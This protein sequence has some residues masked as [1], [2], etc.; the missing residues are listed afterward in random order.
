[1]SQISID[2]CVESEYSVEVKPDVES[3]LLQ[4]TL[5]VPGAKSDVIDN[6][7]RVEENTATKRKQYKTRAKT[8][9]NLENRRRKQ[10]VGI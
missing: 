1:M 5:S 4:E 8:R 3:R 10:K 9:S 7:G 6:A 2:S